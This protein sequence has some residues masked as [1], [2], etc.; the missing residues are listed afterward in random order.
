[1]WSDSSLYVASQ[2]RVFI[3][4]EEIEDLRKGWKSLVK[5]LDGGLP[6]EEVH[7]LLA[8]ACVGEHLSDAEVQA[9]AERQG[10]LSWCC[11]VTA[12]AQARERKTR[13]IGTRRKIDDR[14]PLPPCC[15]RQ[16]CAPQM[17]RPSA[18]V[19]VCEDG[20]KLEESVLKS[21][22]AR[23]ESAGTISY[24]S[25]RRVLREHG[26]NEE[27][28]GSLFDAYDVDKS[29]GVDFSEFKALLSDLKA[30][31]ALVKKRQD[32]YALP[33]ELKACF[34]PQE[35]EGHMLLFSSFDDSGDGQIDEGELTSLLR[36]YGQDPTPEKVRKCIQDIDEDNSGTVS[37]AE[38]VELFRRIQR[39]EVEVDNSAFAQAVVRSD[40]AN[41]LRRE[42]IDLEESPVPYCSSY[43]IT[44]VN[45]PTCKILVEGPSNSPYELAKYTLVIE[46]SES[47]PFERPAVYFTDRI[48]HLNFMLQLNGTTT[49]PQIMN[50]WTAA[51]DVRKLLEAVVSVLETPRLSLLPQELQGEMPSAAT[52]DL[53]E[54]PRGHGGH[55]TQHIIKAFLESREVYLENA[56]A[57][58]KL[59][60]KMRNRKT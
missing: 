33:P 17:D 32:I 49:I 41:R 36:S 22:F 20:S 43:T 59:Q 37:F 25:M 8:S 7:R 54:K 29:G 50:T 45:P 27:N 5:G 14:I 13:A 2:L 53:R 18:A 35:L 60:I 26:V 51:W 11:V 19:N 3:R 24:E 40:T 31:K 23:Y 9:L 12:I 1:M 48:Y 16:C 30:D 55:V 4:D 52:E 57:F 6:A 44:A 46:A 47:Y 15:D 39:G 34:T 10:V 58:A 21:I 42:M 38:F 28:L 56:K